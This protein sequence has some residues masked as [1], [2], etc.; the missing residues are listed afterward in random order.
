MAY[1]S[2]STADQSINI[3]DQSGREGREGISPS[4]ILSELLVVLM[5]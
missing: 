2:S 1:T 4:E 5:K 3:K